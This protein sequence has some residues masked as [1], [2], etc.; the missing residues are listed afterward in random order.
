MFAYNKNTTEEFGLADLIFELEKNEELQESS[1]FK[2]FIEE[3]EIEEI[4]PMQNDS[5]ELNDGTFLIT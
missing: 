3:V 1:I 5:T 4:E 2:S